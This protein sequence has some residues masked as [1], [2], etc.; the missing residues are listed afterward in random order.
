MEKLTPEQIQANDSWA[1]AV[2]AGNSYGHYAEHHTELFAAVPKRPAELLEKMREGWR[3]FRRAVARIGWRALSRTT[4]AG[5][6][7][8]AMLSHLAYWLETLDRT[9]PYRLMGERGPIP[10]VQA[11]NDREQAAAEGRSAEDVVTRLDDAYA[12]VVKIVEGL[13]PDQDLHFMAIR[14][15]AGESY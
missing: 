5:W 4:D 2:V 14:L 6:S 8:K 1:I 9:L 15:L 12:K 7:A 3:P 11:E 10:D 13:P